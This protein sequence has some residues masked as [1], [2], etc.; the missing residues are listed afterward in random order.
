MES[1]RYEVIELRPDFCNNA[2]VLIIGLC[3]RTN[4]DLGQQS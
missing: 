3:V 2:H 4:S 1:K